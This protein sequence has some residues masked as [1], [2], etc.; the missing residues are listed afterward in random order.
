VQIICAFNQT[1]KGNRRPVQIRLTN[2][3]N[4]GTATRLPLRNLHGTR[5]RIRATIV[6]Q[7]MILLPVEEKRICRP[8]PASLHLLLSTLPLH[9]RLN[10]RRLR[11]TPIIRGRALAAA[12]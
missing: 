8:I 9:N 11:L 3:S 10:R 4:V 5:E 2:L 7:A 1:V 6:V 12:S